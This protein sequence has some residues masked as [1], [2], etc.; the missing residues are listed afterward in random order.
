MYFSKKRFDINA[1]GTQYLEKPPIALKSSMA[2]KPPNALLPPEPR[3]Q[4]AFIK[5]VVFKR[6]TYSETKS[7]LN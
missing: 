4:S 7:V 6:E 1:W 3:E 2:L 5:I